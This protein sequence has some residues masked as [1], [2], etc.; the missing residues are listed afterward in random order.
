V[1][2]AAWDKALDATLMKLPPAAPTVEFIPRNG[3]A[4]ASY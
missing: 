4:Q 2:S 1:E 3:W